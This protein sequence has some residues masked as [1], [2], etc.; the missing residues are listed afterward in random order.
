M[1][2]VLPVLG[3][4]LLGLAVGAAG[5]TA[6]NISSIFNLD[7]ELAAAVRR[8]ANRIG[9]R[10]EWLASVIQF[11]SAGTWS[12]SVRN[13]S[14]SATGLIQFTKATAERLGYDLEDLAAMSVL[15]Q[16]EGPV[17]DY[18]QTVAGG[19][20]SDGQGP[21]PAFR[22]DSLQAVAMAVFFPRA[23]TWSPSSSFPSWVQLANPGIVTVADYLRKVQRVA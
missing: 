20:W 15:E 5:G 6:V 4:M 14:S 16:L 13:P 3:L 8:T 23:A 11:E 1:N 21:I 12:P 2:P 22:L 17:V 19:R 9:T 18:F 7:S 10:P